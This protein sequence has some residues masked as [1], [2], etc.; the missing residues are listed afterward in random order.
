MRHL[1]SS[2]T[3]YVIVYASNH[4][5]PSPAPHVRHRRFTDWVN[6]NEA[7]WHLESHTPNRYPPSLSDGGEV[8]FAD[9]FVFAPATVS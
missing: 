7:A 4:D 8:S 1:F 9:F 5:A 6:L 2:A 3:R